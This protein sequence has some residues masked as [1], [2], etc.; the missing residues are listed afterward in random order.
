MSERWER[1]LRSGRRSFLFQDLCSLVVTN[2]RLRTD[3]D[4]PAPR[5]RKAGTFR[6]IGEG[7]SF[8]KGGGGLTS[9]ESSGLVVVQ[10]TI[11]I[12]ARAVATRCPVPSDSVR[13]IVTRY[14]HE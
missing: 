14:R 1:S 6:D 9:E 2:D 13:A 3:W 8:R 5:R 11:A 12:T 4:T 7:E 10:G